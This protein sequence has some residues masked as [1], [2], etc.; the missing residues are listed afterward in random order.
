MS[1]REDKV[2]VLPGNSTAWK[3]Y[4]KGEVFN[5]T[6]HDVVL[7][8]SAEKNPSSQNESTFLRVVST[9]Q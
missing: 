6:D 9:V 8:F 2:V 4:G 1:D 5:L 3:P 7:P